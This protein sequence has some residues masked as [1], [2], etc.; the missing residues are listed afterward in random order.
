MS[1]KILNYILMLEIIYLFP[2]QCCIKNSWM[3]PQQIHPGFS[4]FLT[5]KLLL[6]WADYTCGIFPEKGREMGCMANQEHCLS[7]NVFPFVLGISCSESKFMTAPGFLFLATSV[8]SW[9]KF[10]V[11]YHHS[12]DE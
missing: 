2:K 10:S 8:V 6:L 12:W 1:P 9:V 7:A 11:S 5:E 4:P 3:C